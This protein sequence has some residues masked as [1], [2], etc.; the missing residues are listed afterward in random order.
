MT[1]QQLRYFCEI[2]AHDWNISKAAKFLHT[3]QPGMSCQMHSLE[4]E[5]GTVIFLRSKRRIIGVTAVGSI[6]L[7]KAQ[8]IIREFTNLKSIANYFDK[9]NGATI[10]IA[11]THSQAR[12]ILPRAVKDFVRTHPDVEI[13]LKQG[14]ASDLAQLVERGDVDLSVSSMP[15]TVPENVVILRCAVV[16]RIGVMPVQHPLARYCKLTLEQIAKF[17]IIT[18]D[19]SHIGRSA[20]LGAF[21]RAGLT[22]KIAISAADTDVMK[23]HAA[24]G[25]GIAIISAVAWDPTADKNLRAIKVSDLFGQDTI[26]ICLRRYKHLRR[27][28]REFIAALAPQI[29]A[30]SI[31]EGIYGTAIEL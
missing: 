8:R 25:L 29:D 14:A 1:L 3:S 17:P 10:K 4:K 15:Q 11:A 26:Y 23:A 13:F 5:L 9:R 19:S 22:P 21:E 18:Y 20:V 12:Y 16:E 24:Q 31:A 28:V 27:A 30:A 6:A 2:A 7:A